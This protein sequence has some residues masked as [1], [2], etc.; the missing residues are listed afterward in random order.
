MAAVA[1]IT[2][3]S[4][5][6]T[7]GNLISR[8]ASPALVAA[9]VGMGSL[10]AEDLPTGTNVKKFEKNG[11]LTAASLA[12]S[13]ALAVDS[14]GELTNSSVT[15]T[16]AK[17]A[18]SSGLSVEGERFTN[19]SIDRIA[20]EQGSALA[21][22]VSAD[23]LGMAGGFSTAVTCTD[24]AT[25]A[26]LLLAQFN[27]LNSNVPNP[28]VNVHAYLGARA[29]YNLK[30]EIVQ[31]GAAAWSNPNMLALFGGNG[32]KANG[33]MGQIPGVC[34][35]YQASGFGTSGSDDV[36]MVIHP[37]WA[38]AGMF[39]AGPKTW[40]TPKGSEGLYTEIVSYYLYDIIE[41]N[42]LAGVKFLSD[43]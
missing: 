26:D 18:V 30:K 28:E 34:D 6:V 1:N 32:P 3:V 2:E 38:L 8:R 40:V 16:A 35:V 39:D 23:F 27:I 25:V 4:N 10:Y 14:N 36:Q 9:A 24:V 43:T 15:A 19:I 17:A 7:L 29:V 21:R 41:W 33:F 13:T 31:S 20:S 5:A 12:E 11:S 37:M 42:D 22:Y